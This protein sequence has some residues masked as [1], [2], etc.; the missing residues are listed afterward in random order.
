MSFGL[1]LGNLQKNNFSTP[2][3]YTYI[4]CS[5][6]YSFACSYTFIRSLSIPTMG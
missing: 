5:Y 1:N 3:S 2:C 4:T 6:T